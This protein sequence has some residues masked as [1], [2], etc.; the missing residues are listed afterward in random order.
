MI[1]INLLNSEWSAN[2]DQLIVNLSLGSLVKARPRQQSTF[3]S[4]TDSLDST[5]AV[6]CFPPLTH[7]V[8]PYTLN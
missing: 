4:L 1:I 7:S 2:S 5:T 8:A 3:R 6:I